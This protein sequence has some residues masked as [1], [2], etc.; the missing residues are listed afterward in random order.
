MGLSE[1]FPML[2]YLHHALNFLQLNMVKGKRHRAN[3]VGVKKIWLLQT[4][5]I[6]LK[7]TPTSE[8]HVEG[9][10]AAPLGRGGK[11]K[12]KTF[13]QSS[14]RI[15]ISSF[16]SDWIFHQLQICPAPFYTIINSTVFIQNAI[17]RDGYFKAGSQKLVLDCRKLTQCNY[18]LHKSDYKT[19][20]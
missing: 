17:M 19:D 13:V 3:S 7:T 10:W 8:H 5:L 18:V 6:N 4:N 14:Y 15:Y 12:E 20:E 9:R 1:L 2:G 11:E 16:P